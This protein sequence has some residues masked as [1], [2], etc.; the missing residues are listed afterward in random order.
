MSL[1]TPAALTDLREG[2]RADLVLAGAFLV[3]VVLGSVHWVGLVAGGAL[4][5]L[6]APTLR[7]AF[8]SGLYLG[9]TV[10]LLFALWLLLVGTFGKWA[11]MGQLTLLSVGAS[12]LLPPLGAGIRG[13]V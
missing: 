9:G 6:A 11:A 4:V 5:G 7:R 12:L 3:G 10:L 8:L 2:D 1:L 13:L